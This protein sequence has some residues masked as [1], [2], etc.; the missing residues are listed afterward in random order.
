MIN[1]PQW[2]GENNT[3][4]SNMCGLYDCDGFNKSCEIRRIEIGYMP[5]QVRW[6]GRITVSQALKSIAMMRN[7]TIDVDN[8]V[9]TVGLSSK[10]DQML[11]NLSQDET[12]AISGLY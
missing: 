2:G 9:Q 6:E 8:L 3:Y 5:E 1:R 10:A 4:A 12:A 11:D 7:E